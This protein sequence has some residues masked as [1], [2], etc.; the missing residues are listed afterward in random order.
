[1]HTQNPRVLAVCFL[2]S[3]HWSYC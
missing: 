3:S 2:L 1:M